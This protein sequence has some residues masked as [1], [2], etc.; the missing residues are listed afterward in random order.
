MVVG[1]ESDGELRL[2]VEIEGDRRSCDYFE[3]DFYVSS[4]V[5]ADGGRL[6]FGSADGT[7]HRVE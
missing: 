4:V 7:F 3:N 5:L 1:V 2:S 6:Y